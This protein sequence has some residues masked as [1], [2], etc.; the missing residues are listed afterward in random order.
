[1]KSRLRTKVWWPG[2]DREAEQ[3]CRTCHGCQLVSQP[4]PP[5]PVK[6]TELPIE[7]WK[8]LAADLMGP[9]PSGEYLFVLVDY[10]SRYTE[11]KIMRTV[12]SQKIIEV[13]EEMFARYGLPASLRTDNGPQF[14]SHEFT[15]YIQSLDIED[16]RTTPLWPQANGE[17][18][19]Q[20]RHLLKAMQISRASGQNLQKG[21][22][23]FLTAYRTT[24]HMTT[25]VSPAELHFKRYVC[26]KLPELLTAPPSDQRDR[27]RDS[28][29]KQKQRDYADARR[30]A[31]ASLLQMGDKVL[32]QQARTNKL[33]T[34]YE[35]EP[36]DVVSHEGNQVT[37]ES[38]EGS[39]FK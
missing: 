2:M 16:R 13:L 5:E 14:V 37:L 25:G 12:T 15:D 20:N 7:S 32:L 36:Y 23:E 39:Q 21:L 19:R 33:T 24:P 31:Q 28:E 38:P 29:L 1:M 22:N 10:F 35:F 27:D 4:S 17:V 34:R 6:S 8:D 3:A 26:S 30:N 11:V 9:L 18:E